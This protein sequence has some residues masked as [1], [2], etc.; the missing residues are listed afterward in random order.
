M[1]SSIL[2]IKIVLLVVLLGPSIGVKDV[3]LLVAESSFFTS[4]LLVPTP[5][6]SS[7]M[8]N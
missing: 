6:S 7:A 3:L 1:L 5:T 4:H 2:A 8:I